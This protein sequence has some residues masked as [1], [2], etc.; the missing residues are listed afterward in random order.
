MPIE[1]ATQSQATLQ[2]ADTEHAQVG[3][4]AEAEKKQELR[5][6]VYRLCF[7]LF[8]HNETKQPMTKTKKIT[9]TVTLKRKV[10]VLKPNLKGMLMVMQWR[11]R[12]PYIADF[13]FYF[14]NITKQEQ[15]KKKYTKEHVSDAQA[16]SQ[17]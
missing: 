6:Q 3:S 13:I 4:D 9:K 7:L 17:E 8:K 15:L 1:T 11:V 5:I 10:L 16:K 12:K 2:Q 14:T